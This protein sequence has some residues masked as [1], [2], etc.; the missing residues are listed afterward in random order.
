MKRVIFEFANE[1]AAED[2]LA[3]FSDGGG[4]S[5][6]MDGDPYAAE[7]S[8][9]PCIIRFDYKRAFSA[10]GYDPAKHGP[11]LVVEAQEEQKKNG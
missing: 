2:F 9:R 6:F 8:E 10:W 3:W 4:E 7:E 5:S 1:D 11:D